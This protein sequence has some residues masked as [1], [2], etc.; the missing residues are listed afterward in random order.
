MYAQTDTDALGW[1]T[2]DSFTFTVLASPASLQPQTFSIEISYDNAGP[3]Q[4]TILLANTG[5]SALRSQH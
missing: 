4:T 2:K 3:E 1:K 5:K